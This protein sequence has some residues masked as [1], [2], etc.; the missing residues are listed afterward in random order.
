MLKKRISKGGI[1]IELKAILFLIILVMG[2]IITRSY[3]YL[4]KSAII[5]SEQVTDISQENELSLV[6]EASELNE[7]SNKDISEDLSEDISAVVSEVTSEV[8][9]TS[10]FENLISGQEYIYSKSLNKYYTLEEFNSL[11]LEQ[12]TTITGIGDVTAKAIIN[13]RE[14]YGNFVLFSDLMN[15]KGIGEKKLAK[16]VVKIP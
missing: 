14:K 9:S 6:I 13:Y 3:N 12:L 7:S 10:S 16:W 4:Q 8:T 5:I 11:T 2:L 15:I 1:S